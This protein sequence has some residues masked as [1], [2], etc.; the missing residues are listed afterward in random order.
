MDSSYPQNGMK[1]RFQQNQLSLERTHQSTDHHLP[2]ISTEQ[3]MLIC[4]ENCIHLISIINQIPY[5]SVLTLTSYVSR[6]VFAHISSYPTDGLE[7]MYSSSS[8][9]GASVPAPA[10]KSLTYHRSN[11]INKLFQR[12][13][14]FQNKNIQ[15][16]KQILMLN[17]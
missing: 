16:R 14:Q 15:Y 5:A 6:I 8:T 9:S 7:F 4:F 1:L 12:K 10:R 13:C 11:R 2:A 3:C 17:D